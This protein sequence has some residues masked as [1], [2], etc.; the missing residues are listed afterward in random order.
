MLDFVFSFG[1]RLDGRTAAGEGFV[2][3][4]V[5]WRCLV[6]Q[7]LNPNHETTQRSTKRKI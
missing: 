3:F 6:A 4:R 7:I 5:R 1:K 2:L